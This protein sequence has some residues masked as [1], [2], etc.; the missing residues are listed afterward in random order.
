MSTEYDFDRDA[1]YGPWG[2]IADRVRQLVKPTTTS[3]GI[4][5]AREGR[6]VIK[7][8]ADEVVTRGRLYLQVGNHRIDTITGVRGWGYGGKAY[9]SQHMTDSE[10]VQ[11][12]FGLFRAYEEHECREAFLFDG[13]RVYGPH[14][15]V[16]ALHSIAERT[17]ARPAGVPA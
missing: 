3:T 16:L 1:R 2:D 10:I 4:T 17:D 9:L 11:T 7:L 13:R 15:S 12:V 6:W 5:Y 8:A 14:M